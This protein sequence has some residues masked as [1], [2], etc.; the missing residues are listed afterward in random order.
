MSW[1]S[2]AIDSVKS[3]ARYSLVGGPFGS[4]LTQRDYVDE[5][6]PVIRGANLPERGYPLRSRAHYMLWSSLMVAV[7]N[8]ATGYKAGLDGLCDE[9]EHGR[10]RA[11]TR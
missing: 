4:N 5:G 9:P 2:V 6:V 10:P 8:V 7:A 3:D 11:S 1:P